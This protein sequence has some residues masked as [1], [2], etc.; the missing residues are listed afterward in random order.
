M[1]FYLNKTIRKN[2]V[3]VRKLSKSWKSRKKSQM[4][5]SVLLTV[6]LF[7]E[8]NTYVRCACIVTTGVLGSW[9]DGAGFMNHDSRL[10][11]ADFT[12][13]FLFFSKEYDNITSIRL[14]GSFTEIGFDSRYA[15]VL[16]VELFSS[17]M[18][19]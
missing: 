1:G 13:N 12:D 9:Y 3:S 14:N 15:K 8:F 17:S 16:N 11:C 4:H 6:F 19:F 5:V 2:F 10:D 7:L 18:V